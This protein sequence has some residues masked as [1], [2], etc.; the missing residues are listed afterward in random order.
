MNLRENAAPHPAHPETVSALAPTT[1]LQRRLS[2]L[3]TAAAV[4]IILS[5]LVATAMM[6]G[7]LPQV[8]HRAASTP[9]VARVAGTTQSVLPAVTATMAP[10]VE[11]SASAIDAAGA[12]RAAVA[13]RLPTEP[14]IA[15][16]TTLAAPIPATVPVPPNPAT[17]GTIVPVRPRTAAATSINPTAAI[18]ASRRQRVQRAY[19]Q[20]DLPASQSRGKTREE[21]M[22][23]LLRAKRDGSYSR[24]MEAYR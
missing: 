1:T 5:C 7:L 4:A 2:P 13:G 18:P 11:A 15:M 9:A 16:P 21:V 6:T 22:A 10:G 12:G 19:R 8:P 24:A 17:T 14:G 23:E 20:P 3:E